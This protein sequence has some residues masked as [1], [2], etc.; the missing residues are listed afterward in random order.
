[1]KQT[2][3]FQS[4]TRAFN[5]PPSAR[6]HHHQQS[7]GA[8]LT[9][10]RRSGHPAPSASVSIDSTSSNV[11][12]SQF[13]AE[14]DDA[15]L[16]TALNNVD[17]SHFEA[18]PPSSAVAATTNN[19][20]P[21]RLLDQLRNH[22]PFT[23]HPTANDADRLDG[24]CVEAGAEWHY[25]TN[26][27]LRPYQFN[28]SEQ[29][30]YKNTLVC[31]PTGLGKTLIA[32]VVVSNYRR[33]YPSGKS[34]FMA[35][36]RPLV[37]QQMGACVELGGLSEADVCE[38]TGLIPPARRQQLWVGRHVFF[39][40]PQVLANDLRANICPAAEIRLLVFDEAHKATGNHA[41]CQVGLTQVL[42]INC[43]MVLGVVSIKFTWL[44]GLKRRFYFT[45]SSQ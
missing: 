4:W 35:P 5:P 14:V 36:T 43:R 45:H 30:L 18:P 33:W 16:V 42:M 40:T 2:S 22:R 32:A 15:L 8:L 25:P 26:L 1:M 20:D 39:L 6:P 12:L 31:L 3:L 44:L 17:A 21:A 7:P 38:L 9:D 29:C 24:F 13:T 34:I 37:T 28:I 10:V 41:Y 23:Y 27:S 11:T 19:D